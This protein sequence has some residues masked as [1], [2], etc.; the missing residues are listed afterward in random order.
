MLPVLFG[1]NLF[2]EL[3]DDACTREQ[4][5]VTFRALL[6]MMRLGRIGVRQN[7]TFSDIAITWR[8]RA[9]EGSV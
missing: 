9:Q 7:G 5:V 3:F 2:D 8:Q 1:E 4:I 6:E